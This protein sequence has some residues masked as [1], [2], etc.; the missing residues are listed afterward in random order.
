MWK[1]CIC[2]MQGSATTSHLSMKTNTSHDVKS[3]SLIALFYK[4]KSQVVYVMM[5]KVR[6]KENHL[7]T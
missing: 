3:W 7:P 6:E 5:K 1:E 2:K 4:P